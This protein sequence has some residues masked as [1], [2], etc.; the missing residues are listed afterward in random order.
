MYNFGR[1]EIPDSRD[2]QYSIAPMLNPIP[3]ITEK[4]WWDDGW[5]GNQGSSSCCVAYSWS[6]WMEDGPVIQD[7]ITGRKKPLFDP[8]EFYKA[9]QKVDQWPGDDYAGTSVRAGASI[10]KTVGIITEYRWAF[11]VEE[12]IL[13]LLTLGPMVVGTKWY[14]KMQF[15]N[16]AGLIKLD[17]SSMGGHAY[18]LNGVDTKREYFRIKNSWGR[19][20]GDNGHAYIPFSDFEK[21]FSDGGEACIA[22]ELKINEVP[23]LDWVKPI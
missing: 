6:H 3:P 21:L 17:G 23:S 2:F 15:P 14:N 20:W 16:N 1:L 7:N 19:D 8:Y 12:V 22:A 10:L 11:T 4:F 5:W 13:T 18:L 9:C